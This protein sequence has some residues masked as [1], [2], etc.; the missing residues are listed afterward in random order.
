M[1]A[2]IYDL[3]VETVNVTEGAAF[4]AALLAGT[5]VGIYSS[6][7]EA[8]RETIRTNS[9]TQPDEKRKQIYQEYYK[10]YRSLYP[11]L[12]DKFKLLSRLVSSEKK[13]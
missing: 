9:L 6:V 5:G 10:M 4:G 13:R 12:A 8:C 11:V 1:Q 7:E 2:D 3:P